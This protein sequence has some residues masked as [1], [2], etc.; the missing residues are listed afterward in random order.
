MRKSSF[1]HEHEHVGISSTLM[2]HHPPSAV[3]PIPPT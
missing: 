3:W 2:L 1:G